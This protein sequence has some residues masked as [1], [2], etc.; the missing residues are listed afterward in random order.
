VA[1]RV[2]VKKKMQRHSGC[3]AKNGQESPSWKES[4]ELRE[5]DSFR[6]D[7][8]E[9]VILFSHSLDPLLSPVNGRNWDIK[10]SWLA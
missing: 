9:T 3:Q 10:I 2:K 8:Y 6:I 7:L 5:S 1:E 4:E